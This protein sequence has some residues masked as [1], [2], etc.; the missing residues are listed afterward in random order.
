MTDHNLTPEIFGDF[1]L[2]LENMK[3]EKPMTR[4][5]SQLTIRAIQQLG[6]K[7]YMQTDSKRIPSWLIYTSCNRI[8]YLQ[9]GYFGG[10]DISTVHKPCKHNGT[11]FRVTDNA[12]LTRENLLSGFTKPDWASGINVTQWESPKEFFDSS[13]FNKQYKRVFYTVSNGTQLTFSRDYMGAIGDALAMARDNKAPWESVSVYDED[14][15][16]CD[17]IESANQLFN[18][19]MGM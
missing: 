7:V 19:S 10:F 1:G 17:W 9:S 8:G 12:E 13:P 6:F 14:G 3:G 11:G 15:L 5:I 18:T 4:A 2:H 16:F